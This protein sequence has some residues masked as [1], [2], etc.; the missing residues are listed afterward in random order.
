[1]FSRKTLLKLYTK[2]RTENLIHYFNESSQDIDHVLDVFIRTNSGGTKLEFSDLLMSIAVAHWQG[3]FRR[4]L[5]EL[6]KNIH[7]NNEMGFYIERD[8]FLKTSLM[9]IDSDVRF[10]VK[11]F[12][13]EEVGKI[14][15]QW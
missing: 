6:T 9:L 7:Q 5:D 2:I 4:E 10:K 12:T 13:S 15:Q 8:W 11:N 1:E 3:D 14:Q